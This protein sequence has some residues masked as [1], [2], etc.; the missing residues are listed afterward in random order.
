MIKSHKSDP[1]KT[2]LQDFLAHVENLEPALYRT[3][4]GDE[5]A[6]ELERLQAIEAAAREVLDRF[7][8][9]K[10]LKEE[11][12]GVSEDGYLRVSVL[13]LWTKQDQQAYGALTAALSPQPG[14]IGEEGER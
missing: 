6:A 9:F 13:T 4:K 7:E 12:K 10:K 11:G 5:A 8:W 2:L 3:L 1:H 14:V